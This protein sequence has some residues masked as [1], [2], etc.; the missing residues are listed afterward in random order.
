VRWFEAALPRESES[1]TDYRKRR[2][3][4][5][6]RIQAVVYRNIERSAEYETERDYAL[7]L[8]EA[9]A[10]ARR[11]EFKQIGTT[12]SRETLQGIVAHELKDMKTLAKANSN[13]LFTPPVTENPSK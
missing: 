8:I 1:G 10:C 11:E 3:R 6:G 2:Q 4:Q 5:Q 7:L 9:Y 13:V 12:L